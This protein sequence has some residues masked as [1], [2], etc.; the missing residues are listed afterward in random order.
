MGV[1]DRAQDEKENK[2]AKSK[3]ARGR[4]A[5]AAGDYGWERWNWPAAI[6]LT[7]VICAA[8][9]AVRFGFTR[10]G[11]AAAI[12]VYVGNDYATEYVRPGEDFATACEEI[13]DAWL[14]K[15]KHNWR[16]RYDQWS[17]AQQ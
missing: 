14:G 15:G 10:D 12:G 11:G 9:G 7:E 2:R 1:N 4:R 16:S 13:A 5:S 8:A 3:A 17:A 6:A